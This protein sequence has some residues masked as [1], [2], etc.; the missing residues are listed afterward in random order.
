MERGR[1]AP[2]GLDTDVVTFVGEALAN[3]VETGTGRS[4]R[5]PVV[6]VAGKTGTAQVIAQAT[7][8]RSED[9]PFEHADHAWFTSYAPVA[10]PELVVVVFVEHGGRGS[11]VAAPLA[12][13]MHESY[14]GASPRT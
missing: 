13:R 10:A 1:P 14:F 4:A 11:E 8:T 2:I 6:T 3:V 9:L 7:W 12:R 5:N